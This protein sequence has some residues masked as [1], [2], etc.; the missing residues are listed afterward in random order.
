MAILS[1]F[2]LLIY[3]LQLQL[4][5]HVSSTVSYLLLSLHLM[6]LCNVIFAAGPAFDDS[7]RCH[8]CC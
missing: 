7:P 1:V 8:V 3:N 5:Y 4:S 2:Y 6:I